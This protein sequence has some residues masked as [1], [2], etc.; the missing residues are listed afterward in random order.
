[1]QEINPLQGALLDTRSQELKDK[2]YQFKEIVASAN[3]VNWIEKTVYRKFPIFNQDSSGSC[4]AQT[5]AKMLG[6]M[7]WLKNN[8]YV[9]FSATHIYQRRA[10]KPAGGMAG[11]DVFKIAQKGVTLED[12]VASQN[13]SDYQMDSA[14]IPQYK[15]DVGSVFKIGNYINLPVK[16]IETMASVIQTTGKGLM[17]WFG[18]QIDEWTDIPVIKNASLEIDSQS[19]CRHSVTVVDFT[20]IEIDEN[21]KPII[22]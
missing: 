13:M 1:M 15:Q 9:H 19:T 16:D 2:D 20:L 4:V 21:D 7:Y 5:M 22:K 11:D 8:E 3:P 10:N 12:L 18:F 14:V 6:I 17:T